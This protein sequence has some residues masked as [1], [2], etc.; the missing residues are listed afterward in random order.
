MKL[1]ML[2]RADS[3]I[4]VNAD[5]MLKMRDNEGQDTGSCLWFVNNDVVACDQSCADIAG[6]IADAETMLHAGHEPVP[7][8]DDG[9][10][11]LDIFLFE[12]AD[13]LGLMPDTVDPT[14]RGHLSMLVKNTLIGVKAV[15]DKSKVQ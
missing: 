1:I 7:A 15:A 8:H 4:Y 6:L 11:L 3:V 5:K 12:C 10:P 2:T 9:S 14:K 13:L